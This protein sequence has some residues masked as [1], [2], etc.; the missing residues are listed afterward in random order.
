MT[1]APIRIDPRQADAFA[2]AMRAERVDL[3]APQQASASTPKVAPALR[4]VA[5]SRPDDLDLGEAEAGGALGL[6]LGALL[7]GRLLVQG[8]SGA[9]KSWTLRRLIEQTHGRVQQIVIDPEGDFANL[10]DALGLVALDGAALD[11][12]SI[13]TAALRLREHRISAR[14]DLSQLDRERQMQIFAAFA[15]AL[16]AAPRE[17]WTPALVLIDEAHLF[18]PYG[19]A[20]DGAASLRKESIQ[21]L[22]DL[23]SRGRKRGLAGVIATQRLARM[24]KSVV[25]EALN[26]LVGLNTL[27]IDIRRAAETSGW[28]ARKA[29][30]RLPMLAPGDFVAVGPGFS[31][32][33]LIARIGAVATHHAGARPAL[34]APPRLGAGEGAALI[35]VEGLAAQAKADAEARDD[36]AG[37]P[38]GARAVRAFLRDPSAPLATR[39]FAALTPLA[40]DG[41]RVAD[42]AGALEVEERKIAFALALV[43]SLGAV[44]FDDDGP[45]RAVRLS[46]GMRP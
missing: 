28:D 15:R 41:A 34:I 32:S 27:D 38:A 11:I 21:A 42:F 35:D 19:G 6:S 30:D 2:A 25:S 17:H 18:A 14:L 45:S 3:R 26:F 10:V 8:V 13:E 40:P 23:M 33:S 16:V 7:D 9:G 39:I 44:E 12:A 36:C 5:P 31:R 43:D 46:R 29:F 37:L 22:T 4:V 20:L 1:E 24:A